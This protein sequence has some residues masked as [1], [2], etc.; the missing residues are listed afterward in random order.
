VARHAGLDRS[1]VEKVLDELTA[2]A[3]AALDTEGFPREQHEHVRTADLRYFGQAYEVRVP[4]GAGP[5]DEAAA[6]A[7]AQRFHDEHRQL[8][9]YDFR[10]DPRQQVEWVNLRV[11]GIG[12]ITR[13]ELREIAAAMG[14]PHPA[15]RAPRLLRRGCR[16]RHHRRLLAPGPAGRRHLPRP[17]RH[18]GVRLH[19]SR[20]PRLHRAR[21][22]VRQPRRHQGGLTCAAP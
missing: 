8:Y 5:L 21:R 14:P 1:A 9:G 4:I 6:E 18:R 13:P 19:R 3:T 20:P 10:D 12:P 11:T 17:G 2:L 22:R 16:V 7:V 15:L